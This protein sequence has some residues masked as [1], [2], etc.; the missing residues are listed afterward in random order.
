MIGVVEH[1]THVAGPSGKIRRVAFVV[2]VV[3]DDGSNANT[4]GVAQRLVAVSPSSS[5]RSSPHSTVFHFWFIFL[6]LFVQLWWSVWR[7]LLQVLDYLPSPQEYI[8][9]IL[10]LSLLNFLS[11]FSLSSFFFFVILGRKVC[12][13]HNGMARA[14]YKNIVPTQRKAKTSNLLTSENW[15]IK[16]LK[17]AKYQTKKRWRYHSPPNNYTADDDADAVPPPFAIVPFVV[18]CNEDDDDIKYL[19]TKRTAEN[20]AIFGFIDN[21]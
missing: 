14:K 3:V 1:T 19:A 8:S 9:S 2:V 7:Q 18:D 17:F 11:C 13:V 15:L 4:G 20:H 5:F 16:N 12:D 21:Y 10:V 6:L